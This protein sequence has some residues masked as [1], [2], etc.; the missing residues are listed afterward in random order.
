MDLQNKVA[1]VTGGNGG[2]G[3][4]ICLA[5]ANAGCKIAVVYAK[6]KD[7]AEEVASGLDTEAIAVACDLANASDI[8]KMAIL[9]CSH[10][11]HTEC[12]REV[13]AKNPLCPECRTPPGYLPA[14]AA[15]PSAAAQPLLPPPFLAS[16]PL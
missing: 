15:A 8:Q 16:D 10:V 5:L 13:L 12:I 6:S 9:P 11:F 4:R 7:Q 1:I 3:Q 14:A 2:L